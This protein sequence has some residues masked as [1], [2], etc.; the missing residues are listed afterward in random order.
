MYFILSER[1]FDPSE[2]LIIPHNLPGR[3]IMGS[4]KL[5]RGFWDGM[6]N[7]YAWLYDAIDIVTFNTTQKYRLAI[8][9]YLPEPGQ[10]ILEIGVGPG[11]LHR[12]L[13]REYHLAGMD[14]A[15]GMVRLTQK[16]LTRKDLSSHLCQG[17]ACSL[18]WADASFD[19]VVMAFVL[20]AIPDAALAFREIF[21]IL[22]PDGRIIILDAGEAENGNQFAH[23]L[24]VLW[25]MLGDYI[26]DEREYMRAEGMEITREE[27]GPGGCVHIVEGKRIA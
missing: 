3:S 12:I 1:I 14:L 7:R 2:L 13:A 4:E 21:R 18:P 26:R 17:N 22:R 10:R 19:A 24:A 11:K 6:Y 16:R 27:M 23:Q 25:D 20:S 8:R 9:S 15:W 5:Q